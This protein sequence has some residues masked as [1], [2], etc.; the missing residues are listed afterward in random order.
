MK[1][2]QSLKCL[3]RSE[4]TKIEPTEELLI[5]VLLMKNWI[6]WYGKD[7]RKRS[8]FSQGQGSA[9]FRGAAAFQQPTDVPEP[10]DGEGRDDASA[11]FSPK[12]GKS[13]TR[14]SQQDGNKLEPDETGA[15]L[16]IGYQQD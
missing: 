13:G 16:P 14:C 12:D 6:D 1:K 4:V 2:E 5:E 3:P 8:F 11:Q 10:T 15:K 9:K 7:C